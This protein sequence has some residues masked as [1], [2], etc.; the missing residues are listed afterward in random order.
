MDAILRDLRHA[1]RSLSRAPGLVIVVVLSL[2]LG[3]GANSTV[4]SLMNAVVLRPMPADRPE[5]LAILYT[6]ESD[7]RK[8]GT[9]SY[10]D[11]L[12]FRDDVR[13]FRSLGA[14]SVAPI[15]LASGDDPARRVLGGIATGN[16]FTTL[17]VEA[18]LGRT[19]QPADDE[20]PG[21]SPVAV[22][23]H[24]LWSRAFGS[25]PTVVGRTVRVN[26]HP[27]SVVGV[28]PERFKGLMMGL[29]PD[30]WV[31]TAMV[32]AA[33][34]SS[35]LLTQRG[36][37]SLMVVGRLAPGV[38]IRAA[39]AELD[40]VM[41]RL[42]A[43]HV[44]DS[45]RVATLLPEREA[46]V[47]P[48][49]RGAL[50]GFFGLL[51]AI[52]ALV[53][54]IACLNVAGL[55]LARTTTRRREIGIR[56]AL[57][58]SR[59]RL[60]RQLLTECVLLSLLGGA[61]GLLLAQWG[62]DLLLAFRPPLPFDVVID[63]RPDGRVLAFTILIAM[64]TGIGFG[65]A[66][67]LEA[68]RP[69]VQPALRDTAGGPRRSRMRSV[70]VV[71]Q[72]ALTVVL[73]AGAGLFLRGLERAVTLDPGF[74]PENLHALSFDLELT[75]Y[76]TERGWAFQEQLLERVSAL[77]AVESAAITEYLPMSLGWS[78]TTVS[79]EGEP[80]HEGSPPEISTGI[81]SAGYFKTM[82]IPI[83]HGREFSS[84]DRDGSQ[85]VAI[86]NQKFAE[87][88][89][90]DQNP[91]GRRIT[92]D[93]NGQ[94][95][96]M[97]VVGVA[98][99]GKYQLINEDPRPFVYVLSSQAATEQLTLVARI[100]GDPRQ[101]LAA[102]QSV[103][104]SLDPTLPVFE[105]RAVEELLGVT[106]TPLRM[107]SSLL[108]GF[109]VLGMLL[110][111]IGLSGLVAFSA[112]QRTREIGIRLALGAVPEQIL[113]LVLGQGMRLAWLGLAIG[114]VLAV[115]VTGLVRSWLFG[116]SSADPLTYAA[117]TLLITGVTLLAAWI[118]ARRAARVD[119]MVALRQE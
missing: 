94:T 98:R 103:L 34:P 67:A 87:M 10:P 106:L 112:S 50:V 32:G 25:D 13:A 18:A 31:P 39:R 105:I 85:P 97:T 81:V 21:A 6:S 14:Y 9:T 54:A 111:A 96:W 77:D 42:A 119:P 53:L 41:S 83:V 44:A 33:N 58:A 7:G 27:F 16:Y 51:L 63:L 28:L 93:E 38:D 45:G 71:V 4:F 114:S 11:Y 19:L 36:G 60:V 59:A 88:H 99:N 110:A 62:T 35:D 76:S 29:A 104:R 46:R 80:P 48:Q 118:P 69:D 115:A 40:G 91:I 1:V 26:G 75:G 23:S 109:G 47:M 113:S 72:V 79:V 100:P 43:E 22:L 57:G 101:G 82:R 74:V 66:P 102:I 86:V 61:A 8:W 49:A 92:F 20:A 73:L 95:G 55:M 84:S 37:R 2:A 107:V 68:V 3:I 30:L 90:A 117:V 15:Q 12:D 116:V 24:S 78:R 56:L 65:L 5:E 89:W 108:A 64:A 70:L 52:V 17:G